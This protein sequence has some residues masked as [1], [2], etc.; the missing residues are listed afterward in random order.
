MNPQTQKSRPG[1]GTAYARSQS[2]N[3][4]IGQFR[5]A[6]L[7]AGIILSVGTHIAPDGSLHRA[8]AADDKPGQRSIWYNFHPDAP[9]SGAAGN[10]RTGAKLTWCGKRLSALTASERALLSQRIEKDRAAIQ[11]ELAARH[12]E[13]AARAMRIW[14]Q[15]A[16]ASPSHPYLV[17]K[18]ISSSIARSHGS[19]LVLPVMDFAGTLHG[20]QFIAEDGG[21]RFL[22]GMAK[23]GHF[24]P[25]AG[26]PDGTKL[27]YISEGWATAQTVAALK[28]GVCVIAACDAGNM[29]SVAVEARRRWP[30]LELV[31]CPDFDS[32]GRQ[33][34]QEAATAARAKILP[35]PAEIPANVTD[36]NDWSQWQDW[37]EVYA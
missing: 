29:L 28:P 31:V 6:L 20:L 36:W 21:K 37:R 9:A 11:T 34:G 1:A 3:N 15:S 23:L 19:A 24:I 7:S 22:S 14:H 10:W 5:E 4:P 13:A 32:V 30:G 8:H 25:V 35:P 18:G 17:R 33:K 27:L 12:R 2:H 26:P 16:P